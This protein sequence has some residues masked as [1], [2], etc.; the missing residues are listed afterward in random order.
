MEEVI[1][2]L[3][4]RGCIKLGRFKLSSGKVSNIYIDVRMLYSFPQELRAVVRKILDVIKDLS[5]DYV[6]GIESS[7]IPLATLLA[8]LLNKP[9]I[10][11]RKSAK[12]HGLG[13]E[14]EGFFKPGIRTIVVDDVITSGNS[15]LRASKVL[16][17]N[18][19]IA[20]KAVVIVNRNEGGED[21]LLR[22]GIKLY[23]LVK[24]NDILRYGAKYAKE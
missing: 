15:I 20:D 11:V 1:R 7:G 9:L 24:M 14:I 13:K 17:R 6:C 19:I 8:Y 23:Y 3:Y 12:E 5:F 18:G 10:Y 4:K 2:I 16:R 21:L 22:N